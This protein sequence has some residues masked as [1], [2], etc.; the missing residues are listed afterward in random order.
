MRRNGQ[1]VVPPKP[2]SICGACWRGPCAVQFGLFHPP[3][4]LDEKREYYA[5]GYTYFLSKSRLK[6]S[7]AAG[8]AWCHYLLRYMFVK[9]LFREEV[10]T[11]K[12]RSVHGWKITVGSHEL[13]FCTP[14]NA[15][16]LVLFIKRDLP[17]RITKVIHTSAG[18]FHVIRNEP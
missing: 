12:K 7:A 8:C 14:T 5:G 18:E 6:R 4:Q 1:V 3:I 9:T 16:T 10:K 13:R 15:Q 11:V 2:P 17:A